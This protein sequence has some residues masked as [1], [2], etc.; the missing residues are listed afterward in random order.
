MKVKLTTLNK[1][2]AGFKGE[3]IGTLPVKPFQTGE[4]KPIYNASL[5]LDLETWREMGEPSE[6]WIWREMGE[7][8]NIVMDKP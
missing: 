8:I 3:I 4:P 5:T 1:S 6:L 7:P 2:I